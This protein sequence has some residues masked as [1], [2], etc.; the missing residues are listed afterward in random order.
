MQS[1]LLAFGIWAW[2]MRRHP[3]AAVNVFG[4]FGARAVPSAPPAA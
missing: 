3:V 4:R 1:T 2:L